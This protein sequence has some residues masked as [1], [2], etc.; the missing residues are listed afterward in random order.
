MSVSAKLPRTL[1]GWTDVGMV[2]SFT[3]ALNV[4]GSYH[5]LA[6]AVDGFQGAADRERGLAELSVLVN[7]QTAA[8]PLDL[9]IL[10]WWQQLSA[11]LPPL[12]AWPIAGDQSQA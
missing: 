9:C 3:F 4:S 2:H 7:V 10:S 6:W 1:G 11:L 8:Q 5:Y 12:R